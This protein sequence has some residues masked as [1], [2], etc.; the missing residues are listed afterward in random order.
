MPF[1]LASCVSHDLQPDNRPNLRALSAEEVTVSAANND[2]GFNLFRNLEQQNSGNM[3]IS[4][5]SVGMAL[6]MTLNG[7]SP[8]T[9]ES[10]LKTIEF[11]NLQPSEVN[12]AYKDLTGLLTSMDRTV[13]MDMA[14]SIWYKKELTVKGPFASV[15]QNYYSGTIQGLD[16]SDPSS[17]KTINQWVEGKTKNKIK[18][19]LSEIDPNAVMFLIN[20]IYFKGNWNNQFDPA[21]TKPADFKLEDGSLQQVPMMFSKGVKLFRYQHDQFLLADIPYGNK[22]F[23][24][25]ILLPNTGRTVKDINALLS[26]DSLS[27]WLNQADSIQPELTMPKFKMEWKKDLKTNLMKMGMAM[28]DFPD[29]IEEQL[30]LKIDKVIHQSF[31]EVN[32]QGSEAAAATAVEIGYTAVGPPAIQLIQINRPFL[33][34]IRE[35]HSG[36]ILFIGQLADPSNN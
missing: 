33:F 35:K 34:I 14:N 20:A 25:T 12:Q 31:I 29:L 4:P 3:F 8:A 13:E 18:N 1:A 30:P 6:G 24:M 28:A 10:I 22:Q 17:V 27:H 7:A 15:I 21:L 2:F 19:L 32:E 36:V 9:Q 16:F 11:G 26:A 23:G 5:L